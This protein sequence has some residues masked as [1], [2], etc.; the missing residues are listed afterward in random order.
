M[1]T[2]PPT[3]PPEIGEP[4]GYYLAR[5]LERTV[6]IAEYRQ[7]DLW[8]ADQVVFEKG[9]VFSKDATVLEQL[10]VRD[11]PA[12]WLDGG[13]HIVRVLDGAGREV[14]GSSRTVEGKTLV[15]RGLNRNYRL[16]TRALTKAEAIAIAELLP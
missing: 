14:V 9:F 2:L 1:F 4:V 12:Y 10:R 3:L 6:V 15:W 7:F 8:I 11:Q 5:F 16:E 13:G